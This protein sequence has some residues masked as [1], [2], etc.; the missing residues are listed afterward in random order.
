VLRNAQA[1]ATN[2]YDLAI[3]GGGIYGISIARDAALRGLRVALVEMGDFG[4][5]TSSN[6]HKIIH[7]GFRYLQ[8][9]DLKRM[10]ESIRERRALLRIAPH[11]VHPLPFLIPTYKRLLQRKLLLSLAL[12]L[13]D[14]IGVDR[15]RNLD[16][17][18]TIPR[19]RV[20]SKAGFVRLCPSLDQRDITG[21]AI[22]FDGQ[23]T[24]PNRLNLTLLISAV[25]AGAGVA[26]YV[27]AT[28]FLRQRNQIMG[29]HIRDALQGN[30]WTVRARV[31]V[32]CAGPWADRMVE[33]LGG[34]VKPSLTGLCKSF[35]LVT[36]PLVNGIAVGVPGRF[37]YTDRDAIVKKGFRYFF[38]TPWRNTSLIGTFQ[39]RY[40]GNSGALKVSEQEIGDAIRV[41]NTALPAAE[42]QRHDVI[43]VL[44]G[45][46]PG[47]DDFDHDGQAQLKKHHEIRDH[48]AEDGIEGLLSVIGVKYTTARSVAER[49][50][51]CVFEKLGR[52]SPEC[53]TAQTPVYGGAIDSFE[54]FLAR[55]V[56]TRPSRIDVDTAEHL[57]LTYGTA[58]EEIL[59]YCD[60]EPS[61]SERV[62]RNSP[63]IKAEVLHAV[64]DEMAQKL[65][66][67]IFRRTD[68]GTAGHPG[69]D[70]LAA[71]AEI[72][73][74]EL[75]WSRQRI[76]KELQE[77]QSEFEY[78]TCGNS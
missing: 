33:A 28:G 45:I 54:E 59:R 57:A 37:E 46:V 1:L 26:N 65:S 32:N 35:V 69:D 67:V 56:A 18:K 73:G 9:A 55:A 16:S 34:A 31:V 72:M 68:L 15:N 58:R 52:K 77:V 75:G 60:S 38:I 27:E 49:T 74:A 48:A 61:W 17:C 25:Q 21:G 23:V 76:G 7:G 6:H 13:N 51:D 10:R 40:D 22:F 36:R 64:R 44:R 2:E 70:A 29:I 39:S 71:C 8:H 47:A 30:S 63:V 4:H 41:I 11:L 3:V 53:E 78:A 19:G 24:N 66:D 14:L 62:G 5:A 43:S 50:V 42:L 20:I 12:K